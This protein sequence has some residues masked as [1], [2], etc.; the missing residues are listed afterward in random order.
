TRYQELRGI[1]FLGMRLDG[2][3][4]DANDRR[5]LDTLAWEAAIAA[6]NVQLVE[7]L[8]QRTAEVNL[9]YSQLIQSR[10]AERKRL[11]RDLHDSV[12][13]DLI[14]LHFCLDPGAYD[15]LTAPRDE[16]MALRRR[17]QIVIEDLRQVCIEL[18]PAAL[19]DLSLAFAIQGYIEDVA[20]Q[21]GLKIN[22][23][24]AGDQNPAVQ[25]LPEEVEVCLFRVS[26]E[27]ITNVRRH[28][29]AKQVWVKLTIES[30]YVSL[31]VADDGRGFHWSTKDLR[32]LTRNHHF[33]L[34]G[35]Q[36]Q[37]HLIGGVL[38]IQSTP[39]KGTVLRADVQLASKTVVEEEVLSGNALLLNLAGPQATLSSD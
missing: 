27:A 34:A 22:L 1:L 4:F 25:R 24:L 32:A 31:E 20:A 30:N 10:E 28:A 21:Y 19:D 14:N 6:E 26:Q 9:L 29:E 37:L 2:E 3:S 16:I 7:A 12:I 18:R 13:Q 5:M 33:G 8:R 38:H 17:L 39:G 35:L 36:E 23:A 11:A 15:L